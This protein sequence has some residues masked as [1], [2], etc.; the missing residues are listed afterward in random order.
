MTEYHNGTH[1]FPKRCPPLIFLPVWLK[2]RDDY[3]EVYHDDQSPRNRVPRLRLQEPGPLI[4][5]RG[6]IHQLS[7]SWLR[8]LDDERK[9]MDQIRDFSEYWPRIGKIVPGDGSHQ[10]LCYPCQCCQVNPIAD[11]WKFSGLPGCH[12]SK[13]AVAD[14][15]YRG[16]QIPTLISQ[17][18]NEL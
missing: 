10:P 2:R 5:M 6:T 15:N 13:R 18:R 8:N 7:N 11:T 4:Q 9:N 14:N 3:A 17:Q 1:F 12:R 16:S